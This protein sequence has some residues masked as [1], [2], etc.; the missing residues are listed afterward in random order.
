MEIFLQWYDDLDDIA[1]VIRFAWPRILGFLFAL[2]LF[3]A[4]GVA[5][6]MVPK[7]FVAVAATASSAFLIEA[8]RQRRL[9]PTLR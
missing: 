3:I 8:L 4:T 7:V 9:Q 1:G 5:C 2:S 6:V